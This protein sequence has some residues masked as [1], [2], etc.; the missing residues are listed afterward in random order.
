MA[1]TGEQSSDFLDLFVLSD[2]MALRTANQEVH[3]RKNGGR[4]VLQYGVRHTLSI[5]L[6]QVFLKTFFRETV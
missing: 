5:T 1:N 4:N 6:I 3:D 2:W